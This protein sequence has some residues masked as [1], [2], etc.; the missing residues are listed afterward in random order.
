MSHSV[1]PAR[2]KEYTFISKRFRYYK[3]DNL[4]SLNEKNATERSER[5]LK[6]S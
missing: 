3:H 4:E 1:L 6:S 5:T 2:S